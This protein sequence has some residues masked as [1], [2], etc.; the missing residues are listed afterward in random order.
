MCQNTWRTAILASSSGRKPYWLASKSTSKMGP[1]TSTT[2]I[3]ATRSRMDGMP[4]GRSPPLLLGIHTLSKGC[5]VGA[6]AQLLHDPFQPLL[7]TPG[8]NLLKRDAIDARRTAV[9]TTVSIGFFND[10]RSTDLVPERIEA[11][12]RFSLSF[13]L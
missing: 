3:C 1:I 5:G 9:R 12:S 7:S 8:L 13:C 11:E 10:V 4:S 6:A 2:A